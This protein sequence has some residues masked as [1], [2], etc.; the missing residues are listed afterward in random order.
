M[1]HLPA[2]C[3]SCYSILPVCEN[4]AGSGD[5][6]LTMLT[7]CSSWYFLV[8]T[9]YIDDFSGYNNGFL[10]HM[11]WVQLVACLQT[12]ANHLLITYTNPCPT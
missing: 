4:H 1:R 8:K 12:I 10:P 7:G 6:L 9:L 3:S 11:S 2:C 5:Q